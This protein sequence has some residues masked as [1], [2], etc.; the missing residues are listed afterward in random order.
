MRWIFALETRQVRMQIFF[1]VI[2]DTERSITGKGR[3][4]NVAL[5]D[6]VRC[7]TELEK[8]TSGGLFLSLKGIRAPMFNSSGIA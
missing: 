3:E 8:T 7:R 2:G 1:A 6:R 4:G 5:F